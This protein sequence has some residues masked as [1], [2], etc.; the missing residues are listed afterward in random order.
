MNTNPLLATKL[1]VP[2]PGQKLVERTPLI[3]RL[4]RGVQAKL[5]LLSAPAGFGKTTLL[6]QWISRH[7][8]RVGWISLDKTDGDPHQF[9]KY[10]IAA[11]QSVEPAIGK[12]AITSL[13]SD[14]SP[15]DFI[16]TSLV[17]EISQIPG[18]LVLVFDDYH[19]I[20]NDEI[21]KSIE[22][23]I[24]HS[25][26]QLHL[27][28]ATRVD[29]PFPLARLRARNELTELRISDLCFTRQEIA[30]FLFNMMGLELS[31]NEVSILESRT[32][33]WVAGLQLAAL[34]L[35]GCQDIPSFIR[36]FAGNNRHI[37]D[38]LA[39][40]V[41][42]FQ[43]EYIQRFLLQT[44]ILDRM[45][46]E[47]C[48]YITER[49][50]SRQ[51]LINLDKD[52]LFIIPLDDTRCCYRYHHLFADLLRQ[53]LYQTDHTMGSRLHSRASIW[54]EKNSLIDYAIDH[55]LAADDYDRAAGLI[56]NISETAWEY[57]RKNR[58]FNWFKIL[59][60]EYI[61]K[62]PNLCFFHAWVLFENGQYAAAGKRLQI[63]E[64]LINSVTQPS[65][66]AELQGKVEA[67]R[68][69]MATGQGDAAN[70]IRLSKQALE[71]LPEGA[72]S[73][74]ASAFF[75]LG[76][77]ESIQGDEC[78][79]IEAFS[80]ARKKSMEAGNMH[81][82]FG[83]TFWLAARYKYA[84]Q[85]PR[86]I[87]LCHELLKIVNEKGLE[88]S[89]AGG[90]VFMTRG[91]LLYE[92][93]KLDDAYEYINKDLKIMGRG[94]DVAHMGWCYYGMMRTLTAR[95]DIPGAEEFIAKVDQLMASSN[96]PYWVTHLT[97]SWKA[98]LW[99]LKG[100]S[101]KLADWLDEHE[102]RL[103]D[104]I[105]TA[106]RELG[107]IVLARYL[108][109]Q[110]RPKD[111]IQLLDR[112]LLNQIKGGRIL[113]QIETLLV[114]AQALKT[115]GDPQMAVKITL[116]ALFLAE[117]SGYIRVFLDE[118]PLIFTLL[119]NTLEEKKVPRAFVKKL[120]AE[121][122]LSKHIHTDD[123]QVEQLSER[124]L[125]ILRFIAAGLS[126]K[127]ITEE[128]FISM[129]TVKTHLRNIYSKLGVHSRTEALATANKIDL[130]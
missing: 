68:A 127:K 106:L 22:F 12:D 3:E 54:Y 63:V 13:Q 122:K 88:Q 26:P 61:Q 77:A 9:L 48:D 114:K 27:V 105:T 95:N 28:V 59:P 78:S 47:L 72:A 40:E 21:H 92:L 113:L 121:F 89:M 14:Q 60:A 69:L 79:A 126:N 90:A 83:A 57:E 109:T 123:N 107:Y 19:L 66:M 32:E 6:T 65:D 116:E 52:N 45:S 117:P 71:L 23:L 120:L 129:S 101:G 5:I 82:Y 33:G 93:N 39:E 94:H 102:Y 4:D 80:Q 125:E 16:L 49:N 119:E 25:P 85:L 128:L 11:L 50:E 38:Y 103:D 97:E 76:T 87:E 86:A 74:R 96:L 115:A 17:N 34:S 98:R 100:E 20:D 70:I 15:I 29:P 110:G 43:P 58:L 7:K 112:I 99:L 67:I 84:G 51:I 8:N 44:S 31:D 56:G 130:L 108:I 30:F 55:A 24:E 1:Y 81:L 75:S 2:Q 42:N 36:A 53:R 37:V 62:K 10:F 73:W 64:K 104:D 111:S 41:F 35:Q 91:D 46:G 118:G 124:E 18:E